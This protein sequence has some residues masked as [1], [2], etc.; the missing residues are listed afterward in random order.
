MEACW[1]WTKAG[2]SEPYACSRRQRWRMARRRLSALGLVANDSSVASAARIARPTQY[3][4]YPSVDVSWSAI[5]AW[6][7]MSSMGR[8]V[9]RTLCQSVSGAAGRGGL[10][11]GVGVGRSGSPD[12]SPL[13]ACAVSLPRS[14]F[15]SL[16]WSLMPPE[17]SSSMSPGAWS[18]MSPRRSSMSPG[19]S[20]SAGSASST[21][22]STWSPAPPREGS[23]TR[24]VTE[25]GT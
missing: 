5:S 23:T 4:P 13:R 9:N 6:M 1:R 18:S 10:D 11:G 15:P 20:S 12:A 16:I 14:L 3:A 25:S 7:R 19:G 17:G 24:T 2:V 21:T 22:C 8:V